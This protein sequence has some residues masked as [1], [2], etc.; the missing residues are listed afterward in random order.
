MKQSELLY[1][2]RRVFEYMRNHCLDVVLVSCP[3][4]IYYL[5]DYETPGNPFTILILNTRDE[6]VRLITRRLECSN[7]LERTQ[8]H[9]L[10][11]GESDSCT[12]L[13]ATTLQSLDGI[14][15]TP[16]IGIET[17]YMSHGHFQELSDLICTDWLDISHVVSE[18]RLCKTDAELA[19]MHQA[20]AYLKSGLQTVEP[21]LK[22][23]P[24]VTETSLAGKITCAMMHEGCEYT[25]YPVFV[26]SGVNGC[27]AHHAAARTV[28]APG[29]VVFLEIGASH[30]RYH[31][32][33]MHTYFMGPEPQWFVDLR[34]AMNTSLERVKRKMICGTTC[35]EL[36]DIIHSHI[37][38]WADLYSEFEVVIPERLGYG[39]GIGLGVDWS[40]VPHLAI[41]K[42]APMVLNTGNTLHVIPWVQIGG[43]GAVGFSAVFT[44]AD[45]ES[46][47]TIYA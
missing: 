42:G 27:M 46:T 6:S 11:Y 18:L 5:T 29:D 33:H 19:H 41:H 3:R 31:V 15:A 9:C 20:A 25:S 39:I 26:A 4:N 1:R 24:G 12:R 2:Q 40:E 8:I 21:I 28:I 32:A 7:C 14:P 43:I 47:R 45:E 16:A 22:K 37:R 36:H 17:R 30:C 13:L 23:Y 38:E 10:G 44:V 35:A 34:H